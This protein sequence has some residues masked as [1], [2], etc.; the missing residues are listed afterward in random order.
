[1]GAEAKHGASNRFLAALSN[2]MDLKPVTGQRDKSDM[3]LESGFE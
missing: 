3:L 2:T 1:M